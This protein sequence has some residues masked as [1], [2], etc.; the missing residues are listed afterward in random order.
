MDRT[1]QWANAK[2][3]RR[4]QKKKP[5]GDNGPWEPRT[6]EH[7][8]SINNHRRG[9]KFE[10]KRALTAFDELPAEPTPALLEETS[11]HLACW[12]RRLFFLDK[13]NIVLRCKIGEPETRIFMTEEHVNRNNELRWEE[14]APC[15]THG[16]SEHRL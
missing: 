8:K 10:L 6:S 12:Y 3:H 9:F 2:P 5:E 11:Q 13:F 14:D 7:T 16:S 1:R 15:L 4:R